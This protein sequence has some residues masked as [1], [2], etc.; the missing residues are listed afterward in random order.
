M[1]CRPLFFSFSHSSIL[2]MV[3]IV[4]LQRIQASQ[5]NTLKSKSNKK[6]SLRCEETPSRVSSCLTGQDVT[7]PFL[8]QTLEGQD[9]PP[10]VSWAGQ[11]FPKHMAVKRGEHGNITRVLRERRP[12]GGSATSMAHHR[13]GKEKYRGVERQ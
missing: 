11:V 6:P 4:R 8:N 3:F 13:E 10:G 1:S 7:C 9:S 2:G 12:R 5:P